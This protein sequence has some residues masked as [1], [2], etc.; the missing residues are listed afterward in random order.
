MM[1]KKNPGVETGAFDTL[2][3]CFDKKRD[4]RNNAINQ[5]APVIVSER[6]KNCGV[7]HNG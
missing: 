4:S 1:N 3:G 2:G 5:I 7:R 6:H